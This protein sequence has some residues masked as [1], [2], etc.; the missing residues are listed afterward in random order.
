MWLPPL[1][2][3]V[4]MPHP[5]SRP[6]PPH[7]L[8]SPA[9]QGGQEGQRT[10]SPLFLGF[11]AH[12]GKGKDQGGCTQGE[13]LHARGG[14]GCVSERARGAAHEQKGACALSTPPV[15]K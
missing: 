1:H 7:L 14:G 13:G 9:C 15:P 5:P 6:I 11:A 3:L 10:P 8:S 2:P 12:K 4:Y